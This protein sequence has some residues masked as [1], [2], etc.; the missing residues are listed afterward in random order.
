MTYSPFHFRV[1]K[2]VVIAAAALLGCS[3]D[4]LAARSDWTVSEILD[5]LSSPDPKRRASAAWHAARKKDERLIDDLVRAL[6]DTDTNV[7]NRAASAI[8]ATRGVRADHATL[9]NLSHA[10]AGVRLH[11]LSRFLHKRRLPEELLSK[12]QPRLTDQHSKIRSRAAGFIRYIPGDAAGAVMVGLLKHADANIRRQALARLRDHPIDQSVPLAAARLTDTDDDTRK[13]AAE[14]LHALARADK[15]HVKNVAN[16]MLAALKHTDPAIRRQATAHFSAYPDPRALGPLIAALGDTDNDVRTRAASALGKFEDPRA[17]AEQKKAQEHEKVKP[18]M[19]ALLAKAT[20]A[21]A[22]VALLKHRDSGVRLAAALALRKMPG[23]PAMRAALAAFGHSDPGVRRYV[24]YRFYE[25]PNTSALPALT[26]ALKDTNS[27]VRKHAAMA[28]R[29]TPGEQATRAALAAWNHFDPV[30][31][32]HVTYRF[33]ELPDP[34]A[35]PKLVDALRDMDDTVR[36][37]ASQAL[38]NT[39]GKDADNAAV[40]ALSHPDPA[41]RYQAVYRFAVKSDDKT[42]VSVAAHIAKAVHD[43]DTKVRQNAGS[44][45][46]KTPGEE[47]AKAAVAAFS[48][49]DPV[50]RQYAVR[51]FHSYPD[52]KVSAKLIKLLDD[53]LN[54]VRLEVISALAHST[55]RA[56]LSRLVTLIDH[57]DEEVRQRAGA[58][59]RT[60]KSRLETEL[61]GNE[62][63]ELDP[64]TVLNSQGLQAAFPMDVPAAFVEMRD[65]DRIAGNT[66]RY[67]GESPHLRSSAPPHLLIEPV[68]LSVVSDEES[69]PP[70]AFR[71]RVLTRWIRRVVWQRSATSRYR[72]ST[73]LLRGGARVEFRSMRWGESGISVLVENSPRDIDFQDIAELHLPDVDPW[74]AYYEQL[75]SLGLQPS[76]KLLR[77]DI[78]DGSSVTVVQSRFLA[79]FNFA[80]AE[81]KDWIHAFQPAWSLDTLS[82]KRGRIQMRSLLPATRVPLT[83]PTEK[84]SSTDTSLRW[85][86]N[87]NVRGGVL[88]SA[89][90]AFRW[91]IGVHADRVL[92]FP[93]PHTAHAIELSLGLDR[94]AGTRGC[95]RATVQLRQGGRVTPLFKSPLLIGSD[96]L[97]PTGG[98]ELPE[99]HAEA[100]V[101]L[102]ADSAH[103][104][105]TLGADPFNIR[106]FVNWIEPHWQLDKSRLATS[107]AEQVPKL[108]AAQADWTLHE[109]TINK[110]C[111][112]DRWHAAGKGRGKFQSNLVIRESPATLERTIAAGHNARQLVLYVCRTNDNSDM[113]RFDVRID[114]KSVGIYNVPVRTHPQDPLPVIVPLSVPGSRKFT[115]TINHLDKMNGGEIH[116][117]GIAFERET[118]SLFPLFED[119]GEFTSTGKNQPAKL[120]LLGEGAYSGKRMIKITPGGQFEMAL[121]GRFKIR[122]RPTKDELRYLRFAFRK[123]GGG[124]LTLELRQP[125]GNLK[126]IR[127]TV[128]SG[129]LHNEPSK[130]H[131]EAGIPGEWVVCQVDLFADWGDVEIDGLVLGTPDG[132]HALVDCIYLARSERDFARIPNVPSVAETNLRARRTL[133]QPVLDKARPTVVAIEAGGRRGTGVLIGDQGYVLTASSVVAELG[134]EATVRMSDGIILKGRTTSIDKGSKCGVIQLEKKPKVTGP[135][136]STKSELPN[137]GIYVGFSFSKNWRRAKEAASYITVIVGSDKKT[138]RPDYTVS[139]AWVGGPL[140]DELGHVVGIQTGSDPSGN[141]VF[142]RVH[143]LKIDN[144][145]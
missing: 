131:W 2:S 17:K 47:A 38:Q 23:E 6:S 96:K 19:K 108:V 53:P 134:S 117:R 79:F 14:V 56:T 82:T 43:S 32:Q 113:R 4:A 71:A 76:D 7:R 66:I 116:W 145:R 15:A 69:G 55:D 39:P 40:G 46:S 85:R 121:D 12:L 97:Y 114:G 101:E 21:D 30:V 105:R 29:K 10:R 133:S 22:L 73:V 59:F 118:P 110:T 34:V 62:A 18:D 1:L 20:T 44:T 35:L 140:F 45:L 94:A 141:A 111:F 103:A 129:K 90:R 130:R 72:P 99:R 67:V 36:L 122:E 50:V 139:G 78:A 77:L 125:D 112:R 93:V 128:G 115:L 68:G 132:E 8:A 106:D 48:H 54:E 70:Q 57:S 142:S 124:Q 95:A 107:L 135:E 64:E 136:L 88:A 74:V 80:A 138:F 33:Y 104:E 31:R 109:D 13:Y 81:P 143:N 98:L 9:S 144:S 87:R 126:P 83:V 58:A 28:I 42:R 84:R 25:L 61:G 24:V 26:N 5:G 100:M 86:V 92:Q 51:Y 127:Y 11:L 89:N 102:V 16:V 60:F 49:V 119:H 41:V 65:G 63:S 37:Y 137:I 123:T 75:A 91:G 120:T 27:D 3:G 52:A